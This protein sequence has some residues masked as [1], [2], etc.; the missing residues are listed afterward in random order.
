MK[1]SHGAVPIKGTAST[2]VNMMTILYGGRESPSTVNKMEKKSRRQMNHHASM[3]SV[4]FGQTEMEDCVSR[5]Q[6]ANS[7]RANGAEVIRPITA[8][9][10]IIFINVNWRMRSH[11][12]CWPIGPNGT[13]DRLASS[14]PTAN[15][16][17]ISDALHQLHQ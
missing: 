13:T 3:H 1:I 6:K 14:G 10:K 7:K 17:V 5:T 11:K 16:S 12:T 8:T 9:R 2:L 4:T 15:R